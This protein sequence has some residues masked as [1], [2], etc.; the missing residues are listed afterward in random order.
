MSP[1]RLLAAVVALYAVWRI[2]VVMG[3]R[4]ERAVQA[5]FPYRDRPPARRCGRCGRV[6]LQ[7][8][9]NAEGRWPMRRWFCRD[10]C[11]GSAGEAGGVRALR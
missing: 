7:A 9:M 2:A 4:R 6:A 10:G 8:E 1:D 5:H 11:P 3:R